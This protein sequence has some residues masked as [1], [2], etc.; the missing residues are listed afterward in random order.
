M[1]NLPT[2]IEEELNRIFSKDEDIIFSNSFDDISIANNSNTRISKKYFRSGIEK[3]QLLDY[4]NS[5]I[6]FNKSIECQPESAILYIT[7]GF[8]K[9]HTEDYLGAIDDFKVAQSLNSLN[10]ELHYLNGKAKLLLSQ[11]LKDGGYSGTKVVE[12]VINSSHFKYNRN[13]DESV[14]II[15]ESILDFTK[16]LE[17]DPFDSELYSYRGIAKFTKLDY[18]GAK[19]DLL[20]AIELNNQDINSLNILGLIEYSLNRIDEA[21]RY[22][23][24]VYSLEPFTYESTVNLASIY[25]NTFEDYNMTNFYL[26]ST[27]YNQDDA[28]LS[29]LLDFI[30]DFYSKFNSPLILRKLIK[31]HPNIESML[32]Y[33]NLI[34]GSLKMYSNIFEV[35]DYLTFEKSIRS[36]VEVNSLCIG[37]LSYYLNDPITSNNLFNELAVLYMPD[38]L[39]VHYYRVISYP[40]INE[41]DVEKILETAY[42][43]ASDIVDSNGFEIEKNQLYYCGMIFYLANDYDQ[44]L[45]CFNQLLDFLPSICMKIRILNDYE[46]YE[47]LSMK[48]RIQERNK[49][50]DDLL[51]YERNNKG[52]LQLLDIP[53]FKLDKVSIEDQTIKFANLKEIQEVIPII[54]NYL[55]ERVEVKRKFEVFK[56]FSFKDKFVLNEH[57]KLDIDIK[58]SVI[59]NKSISTIKSQL[60]NEMTSFSLLDKISKYDQLQIEIAKCIELNPDYDLNMALIDYFYLTKKIDYFDKTIL[61]FYTELLYH[62]KSK[63]ESTNKLIKNILLNSFTLGL[64]LIGGVENIPEYLILPTSLIIHGIEYTKEFFVFN[65]ATIIHNHFFSVNKLPENYDAFKQVILDEWAIN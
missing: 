48:E 62:E 44:A 20:K 9:M 30:L 2:S 31:R 46:E 22:F 47:D 29:F 59:V 63:Y 39:M 40:T 53:D 36:N 27:I 52:I 21:L 60:L 25:Y 26:A 14:K 55:D 33:R 4:Q 1:Y 35:I 12:V 49:L 15:N 38:S 56:D 5:I 19:L 10:T 16:A 57:F 24:Q 58:I 45:F 11:Q 8:A 50:I 32:S 17:F 64:T 3:F 6:E 28:D 18:N 34:D 51:T 65:I 13:R 7:R 23:K 54:T 61:T 37:V 43:K 41:D 42:E